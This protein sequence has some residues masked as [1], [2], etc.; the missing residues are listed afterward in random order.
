MITANRVTAARLPVRLA[1]VEFGVGVLFCFA[2]GRTT[3]GRTGGRA[4]ALFIC[5]GPSIASASP[6]FAFLHVMRMGIGSA[7]LAVSIFISFF[8][9]LAR[10]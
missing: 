3:T 6:L 8:Y 4:G 1:G 5:D 10:A 2:A 9:D 7:S